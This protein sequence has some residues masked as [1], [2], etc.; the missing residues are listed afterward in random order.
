MK[1]VVKTD[2]EMQELG[3]T[4]AQVLEINDVVYL[5]GTLGAGKTTLVRGFA[6]G[7]SYTG[8]ITSPT[9]TLMNIYETDPP[10]YHF[11]FYRL[12]GGDLGDLG[13]EDYLEREGISFIEWPPSGTQELPEEAMIIEINLTD[14]DYDL[15]RKVFIHGIG[16]RYE[17]KIERLMQSV[18]SGVR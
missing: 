8:R 14:D 17:E 4:L 11:D 15:E 18:D 16:K 2:E 10:I 7:M 12:E 6:R 13:L 5:I 1:L 3:A 9:F